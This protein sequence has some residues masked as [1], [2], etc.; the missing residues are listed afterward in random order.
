MPKNVSVKVP[1]SDGEIAI[2]VGGDEP[3]VYK[4]TDG[5]V[6]VPEENVARFL[7]AVDGSKVAGGTTTAARKDS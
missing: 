2:A 7:A 4:V 6:S 1:Q 3:K 5:A